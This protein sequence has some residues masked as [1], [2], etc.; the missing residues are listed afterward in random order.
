MYRTYGTMVSS[1]NERSVLCVLQCQ[2]SEHSAKFL[3]NLQICNLARYAKARRER[4]TSND[5]PRVGP[6]L[7]GSGRP[8]TTGRG[9]RATATRRAHSRNT[10]Q[11]RMFP[12]FLST[13]IS[14]IS[15]VVCSAHRARFIQRSQLSE[16]STWD[17]G[18]REPQRN[19]ECRSEVVSA[20]AYRFCRAHRGSSS[21]AGHQISAC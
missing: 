10:L 6:A 13:D 15:R 17:S 3:R 2:S 12:P 18:T 9:R 20:T 21:P 4:A 19:V 8:S 11:Y 16:L 7:G 1:T 5:R 14:A